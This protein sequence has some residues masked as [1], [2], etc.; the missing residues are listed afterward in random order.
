MEEPINDDADDAIRGGG[1]DEPEPDDGPEP[2][3]PLDSI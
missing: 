3:A 1:A 2:Q